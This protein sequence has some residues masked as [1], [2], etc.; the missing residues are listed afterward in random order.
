MPRAED[1]KVKTARPDGP[2]RVRCV[3]VSNTLLATDERQIVLQAK[4]GVIE[5]DPAR[6]VAMIAMVDRLDKKSG[7]ATAFV[8]GFGLKAG[9][10]ASTHNAICEN[11]AIVGTNAADMTLATEK[12]CEMGGGQVIVRDG[13]VV[14]AFPMPVLGLFSDRPFPEV[15]AKRMEIAEAARALGCSVSDPLLK[16]EFAFA[17]AEFPHLR[18]SEEGLLR[19]SPRERVALE[20]NDS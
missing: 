4:G 17:A 18:M 10:M 20:V 19:T 6:N 2:V 9:A 1:F 15:L 12:L 13:E 7:M 5:P 3:G 16:L 8:H 11:L 14:A